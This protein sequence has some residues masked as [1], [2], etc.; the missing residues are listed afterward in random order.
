M[1]RNF[2]LL[3]LGL[4]LPALRAAD[5]APTDLARA[6]QALEER[7]AAVVAAPTITV[8]HF[9]APWC[10]N[11]REELAHGGWKK[12]IEANPDVQFVFITTWNDGQGDGRAML[13]KF[14]VGGQKNF[15]LHLHPNGSRKEEDKMTKFLGLPVT[16]LPGTWIFRGG[17]MRFALNYGELRFPILQ[18][19][20]DDTKPGQWNR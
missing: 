19:L 11:C 10:P 6:A 16:W 2:F 14:G 1:M 13:E 15:Q 17:K 12:A 3:A 18:Q 7:I 8:V 9:W 20:L 5:A 4:S